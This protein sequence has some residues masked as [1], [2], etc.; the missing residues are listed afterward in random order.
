MALP[1]VTVRDTVST[2]IAHIWICKC[3]PRIFSND[4]P[5]EYLEKNLSDESKGTFLLE[6]VAQEDQANRMKT[7]PPI[8]PAF[9]DELKNELRMELVGR[10]SMVGS[11]LQNSNRNAIKRSATELPN[12]PQA[13]RPKRNSLTK[14][15]TLVIPDSDSVHPTP[16]EKKTTNSQK[17][18]NSPTPQP[19]F[20]NLPK[21]QVSSSSKSVKGASSLKSSS[22]AS[23]NVDS[24]AFN[25]PFPQQNQN[26]VN[27]NFPI[28]VLENIKNSI[29][30]IKREVEDI[31]K[32]LQRS[33]TSTQNEIL[34]L[35]SEIN[36][37]KS[38]ISS[39]FIIFLLL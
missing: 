6:P 25:P 10:K 12:Q 31:R 8:P 13:K 16:L 23:E 30:A 27:F 29:G 14:T 33:E 24:P 22:S 37:I 15:E 11:D 28:S 32:Y 3:L 4:C 34:T 7:I 1:E 39:F 35:R 21:S 17:A 38:Q 20:Q 36:Q 19:L 18:A 2:R 9:K 5:K 26:T